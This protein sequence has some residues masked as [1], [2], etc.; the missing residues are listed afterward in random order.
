HAVEHL[1]PVLT[2][3]RE[4]RKAVLTVTEGWLQF[5]RNERLAVALKDDQG[6][7]QVP[8]PG[9][10]G[11]RLRPNQGQEQVSDYDRGQCEADRMALAHMDSTDR[12]RE[13]TQE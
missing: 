8:D 10:F 3:L 1:A 6:T 7:P 5:E 13:I 9:L 11:P 12:L 2:G 4:E